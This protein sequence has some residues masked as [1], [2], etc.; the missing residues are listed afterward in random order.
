MGVKK[1]VYVEQGIYI[2][3]TN[4]KI[5][6]KAFEVAKRRKFNALKDAM[7]LFK[8]LNNTWNSVYIFE[9]AGG[10]MVEFK[11]YIDNFE[12]ALELRNKVEA[13]LEVMEND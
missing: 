2:I 12:D 7:K 3:M 10:F 9:V 6:K 8:V 4:G 11:A 13:V 1:R 5:P